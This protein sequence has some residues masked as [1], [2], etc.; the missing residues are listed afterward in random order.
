MASF[1]KSIGSVSSKTSADCASL[2]QNRLL[3]AAAQEV[4]LSHA[5]EDVKLTTSLGRIQ[6]PMNFP[7]VLFRHLKESYRFDN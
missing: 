2:P 5:N 7:A 6:L 4:L 1:L 3:C